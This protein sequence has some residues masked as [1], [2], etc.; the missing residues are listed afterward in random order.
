MNAVE[1]WFSN[2]APY[3][4]GVALYESLNGHNKVLLSNFKKKQSAA[5]H[6]K[7]KYE[8][9]KIGNSILEANKPTP[10]KKKVVD[11]VVYLETKVAEEQNKQTLFFHDLP[12]ALRPVLLEANALFREN[13]LLK[14]QLNDLPDNAVKKALAIQLKISDNQK[15]NA[16]CWN[17]IDFWKE[18]KTVP[19][20]SITEYH[21]YS[22]GRLIKQEQ[23]H[24]A[25]ISKLEKRLAENKVQIK[26]AT[27]MKESNK[28][29]RA[30]LRQKQNI[31]RK[32]TELITIKKMI[33]G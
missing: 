33:N 31:L 16:V 18:F 22:M 8:I 24:Y 5:L 25:A 29:H 28:I 3:F 19:K 1:Q 4:E 11:P 2:K 21:G 23:Y 6:E 17:K 13:C 20:E 12:E 10:I 26:E 14:V 27:S 7:L 15:K 32:R 30:I 9:R